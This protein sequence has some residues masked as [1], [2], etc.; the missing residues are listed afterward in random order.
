MPRR[1]S[2][3]GL[4]LV[5][6]VASP[7][8]AADLRPFHGRTVATWANIFAGFTPAGAHFL[9]SGP[10]THMGNTVQQ[11]NLFFLAP[12]DQNGF[13][14]GVGSVTLTAAN[15]DKLTFH[16]AGVLD[17]NTGVGDGSFVFVGGTGRFAGATG[18]GSFH[19]VIDLSYPVDQPMTVVLDGQVN[20]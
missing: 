19:A 11:G 8:K 16:Y 20:Y 7:T 10:V 18:G 2:L 4:V 13:A 14:P 15:G 9:G 12:P 5:L 6:A 17:G 3:V 1:L